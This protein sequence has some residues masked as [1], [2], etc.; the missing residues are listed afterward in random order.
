M[1]NRMVYCDFV[2]NTSDTVTYKF[3][4]FSDDLSGLL[5][6]NFKTGVIIISKE[7][8]KHVF[9]RHVQSLMRKHQNDFNNGI[10]AK[11]IAYEI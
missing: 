2:E 5:T 11:K 4:A 6:F 1:V 7:P 9:N 8:N 10:F 3:G